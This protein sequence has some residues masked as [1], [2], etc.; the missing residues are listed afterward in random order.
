MKSSGVKPRLDIIQ[1]GED[2]ATSLYVGIKKGVGADLGV[3]VV[4]HKLDFAI[5]TKDLI[6]KINEIE[7][8]TN[9]ILVQLPL[10]D[11]IDTNKVLDSVPV[12]LDVDGLNSENLQKL[13]DGDE[14]AIPSATALGIFTLL[15]EYEIAIVG[16][17]VCMIGN[18]I[19]V[20]QPL[21]A[22]LNNQGALVT[23]CNQQ[24]KDIKEISK[25]SDILITATGNPEMITREWL[26]KDAVV[27]D[28]GISRKEGRIVGDVN[29]EDVK[30]IVSYITPVPG[31]VGPMTVVCLFKNLLR[32]I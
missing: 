31:G 3:E 26:N 14:T 17:T 28:V 16:K 27:V 13:K 22:I 2:Y 1:V 32:N 23:V 25:A 12:H 21:T 30:D 5:E 29:Y 4:V 7:S 6:G 8:E 11:R 15:K 18:S 10:P 9:G 20:G 24:T 19:E